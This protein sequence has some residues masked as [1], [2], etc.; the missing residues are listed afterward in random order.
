MIP[1]NTFTETD[2]DELDEFL[3]SDKTPDECMDISSLD[4]FLTCLAIGPETVMPS[5]WLPEIWGESSSDE[6]VWDSMEETNHIMGLILSYFNSIVQVFTTNPKSFEPLFYTKKIGDQ[7][8]DIIDEWCYGFMQG[9][10]L[11]FDS[12]KPMID[13]DGERD[14]LSPI[15]LHG[16]KE[17]NEELA[18]N[19]KTSKVEHEKWVALIPLTVIE[20]HKFWL[21][22]RK[23][24]HQST[25]KAIKYAVGRN[26]PCPCGSGKKFKKC[27]MN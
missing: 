22:Y 8:I 21:P 16:T 13:S 3:L 19:V 12:W 18:R 9:V 11:T 25:H 17:G 6:M 5:K 7:E 20:I 1:K 23:S 24:V 4:G 2:L 27:C 14:M 26:D 10:G 15:F